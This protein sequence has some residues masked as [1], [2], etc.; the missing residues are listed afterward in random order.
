[1]EKKNIYPMC[2]GAAKIQNASSL[3][4]EIMLKTLTGKTLKEG[5]LKCLHWHTWTFSVEIHTLTWSSPD[6]WF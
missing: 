6:T 3:T 1:M 4:E 5:L 2:G